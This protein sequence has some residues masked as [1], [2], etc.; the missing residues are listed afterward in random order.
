MERQVNAISSACCYYGI[1]NIGHIGLYIKTNAHKTLARALI[2]SRLDH[3]NGV[4]YGLPSTSMEC[5]RRA[6]N[7]TVWL[8]IRTRKRKHTTTPVLNSLLWPPAIYSSQYDIPVCERSV[9]H[10]SVHQYLE[11]LV[12]AYHT[13]H[14]LRSDAEALLTI[15]RTRAVMYS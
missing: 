12:I 1:R 5:L 10:V 3:G 4:P 15:S 8:A 9:L 6:E 11:E 7:S 14:S 13:T 2:T